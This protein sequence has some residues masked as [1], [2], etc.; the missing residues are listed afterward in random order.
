M[1]SKHHINQRQLPREQAPAPCCW[2]GLGSASSTARTPVPG[3]GEEG[4]GT[5]RLPSSGPRWLP[6]THPDKQRPL[7][8]WPGPGSGWGA[9]GY[10]VEGLA[11]TLGSQVPTWEQ[12]GGRPRALSR[13]TVCPGPSLTELLKV[14]FGGLFTPGPA[15]SAPHLGP[16]VRQ[17]QAGAF[18]EGSF[19][20]RESVALQL[21]R[22]GGSGAGGRQPVSVETASPRGLCS[23]APSTPGSASGHI[24]APRLKPQTGL[25]PGSH[26]TG[27]PSRHHRA[28]MGCSG[29]GRKHLT[30]HIRLRGHQSAGRGEE[31]GPG[32]QSRG[33]SGRPRAT[34]SLWVNLF[35]ATS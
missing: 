30:H 23:L 32:W 22:N 7:G 10:G 13:P 5:A 16:G 11:I 4:R 35:A 15:G 12:R 17:P 14:A 19:C 1:H 33:S 27:H 34:D 9:P 31:A 3:H 18:R 29:G 2:A 25:R 20:R 26:V 8:S 28:A 24:P 6:Q 21:R